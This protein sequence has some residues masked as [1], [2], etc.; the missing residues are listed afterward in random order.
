M[1][2]TAK[3]KRLKSGRGRVGIWREEECGYQVNYVHYEK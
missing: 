3:H 1:D 2:D